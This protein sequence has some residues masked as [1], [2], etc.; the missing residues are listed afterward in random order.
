LEIKNRYTPHESPQERFRQ[1]A[2]K[3]RGKCYRLVQAGTEKKKKSKKITGYHEK[4]NLEDTHG[5]KGYL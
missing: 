2:P 1:Y 5:S 3:Q 4:W